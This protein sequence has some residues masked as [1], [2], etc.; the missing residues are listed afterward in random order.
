MIIWM[1]LT[2]E[3]PS[4]NAHDGLS[5]APYGPPCFGSPYSRGTQKKESVSPIGLPCFRYYYNTGMTAV[6]AHALMDDI[7]WGAN[8]HKYHGPLILDPLGSHAPRLL[9]TKRPCRF[10]QCDA[11]LS[12]T[13]GLSWKRHVWP[14][15][16]WARFGKPEHVLEKGCRLDVPILI[17]ACLVLC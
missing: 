4:T 12:W 2:W 15:R 6:P 1:G 13:F 17:E 16:V 11:S 9:H 5:P 10:T 3:P 7:A 14:G 8:I